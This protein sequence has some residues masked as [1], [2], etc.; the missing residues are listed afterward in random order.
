MPNGFNDQIM[1]KNNHVREA[2]IINLQDLLVAR[3]SNGEGLVHFLS[4]E[5]YQSSDLMCA[6]DWHA[7][8]EGRALHTKNL[9]QLINDQLKL[10]K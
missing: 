9:Y 2:L 8:S 7:N 4:Q 5:P 10:K 6:D 3:E 1:K